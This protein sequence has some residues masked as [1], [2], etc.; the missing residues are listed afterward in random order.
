M[1]AG[2]GLGLLALLACA[3]AAS[4]AEAQEPSLTVILQNEVP[5]VQATALLA[6][7]KFLGLMRSGFPLRLHY[8]L[9]LWRARSGWFDQ[10]VSEW[11]WDAVAHHDPLAD[12]F[13]LIRT[14][15]AVTRFATADSLE[16]ALEIPYRV[17]LTP[18]GS[19][20][21]YFLC[22]LD[23]TTL[24]DTDLEELTRWLKGDVSPAVS[25]G[26]SVGGALARG[27]QRI[28][29][30]IAGLPRLTLEARSETFSRE[31]N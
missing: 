21:F 13:V 18:K 24:N 16:R 1:R 2:G 22:R 15:G 23:V 11:S 12:D 19:G 3:A 30:R 20:K 6:D 17:R 14:G 25:G 29:V 10:F 7:G 4:P 31:G 27:A 5:R 26:G 28:L 8:R 9:E